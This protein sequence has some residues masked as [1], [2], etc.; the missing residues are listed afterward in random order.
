MNQHETEEANQ[1]VD[2]EIERD[3]LARS[4]RDLSF[5]KEAAS[6]VSGYEFSTRELRW[7]WDKLANSFAATKE[8]PGPSA[9]AHWILESTS[10]DDEEYHYLVSAFQNLAQRPVNGT[11]AALG[12]IR[13]FLRIS[14]VRK[15]AVD[16]LQ[17]LSAADLKGAEEALLSAVS[18]MREAQVLEA[19]SG[20][21]YDIKNRFNRYEC[22]EITI[23]Y[24]IPT[25]A[26]KQKTGGGLR[27]GNLAI[28]VAFTNMGKTALSVAWVHEV[29]ENLPGSV[30]LDIT[31]EETMAERHARHD[32][33]VVRIDR[34]RLVSGQMGSDEMSR[35]RK[36]IVESQDYLN[37]IYVSELPPG[38]SVAGVL[39]GARQIRRMHPGAPLFVCIDSADHLR[40]ARRVENHR[41]GVVSVFEDI[42]AL[43]KDKDIMPCAG[44]TTVQAGRQVAQG[45]RARA[46]GAQDV[47]ESIIKAQIATVGIGIT[48]GPEDAR[49]DSELTPLRLILFKNRLGQTK[50]WTVHTDAHLGL[51]EFTETYSH[52]DDPDEPN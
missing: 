29:L 30:V 45:R 36:K 46:P 23:R 35:A 22:P 48:D 15:G 9:W 47:S 16:G 39:I 37:R 26:L 27:P 2:E 14:A 28:A 34:Q 11:R 5:L 4:L 40:A 42:A 49:E 1:H 25:E 43:L 21:G 7:V 6:V 18:A 3:V 10:D 41:L 51:C 24:P 19:P 12:I 8:L 33:R 13:D 17:R 44:I 20:A 31:T 50:R 52:S 32:A 38:S